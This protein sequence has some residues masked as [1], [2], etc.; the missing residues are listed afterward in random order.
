MSKI[1]E[2]GAIGKCKL[3]GVKGKFVKAHVIPQVYTRP[4][5]KGGYLVQAGSG[6][7]PIRRWTSWY[8]SKIVTR[9]G[10]DILSEFDDAAFKELTRLK[11]IWKSWGPLQRLSTDDFTQI[12]ST[13]HGVIKIISYDAKVLR[14]FFLSL[15]WR[16]AVSGMSEFREIVL[17]NE[18]IEDLRLRLVSRDPGN[19]NYFPIGIMQIS[20]MGRQHNLTPLF[21]KKRVPTMTEKGPD[22]ENIA[23]YIPF[24]RFYMDGLI[25]HIHREHEPDNNNNYIIGNAEQL[26]VPTVT[27]EESAQRENLN[28]VLR[29][30]Y[31]FWPMETLTL[32]G[33]PLDF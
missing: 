19:P 27:F 7:R 26:I 18:E 10:E 3:T 8:D 22:F 2:K 17:N 5:I 15:L 24:F 11:L 9:E 4:S 20:T 12:N 28:N 16:A 25:I 23:R 32:S 13:P 29:S 1:K 30:S 6:D 33:P 31:E 14:L 21:H